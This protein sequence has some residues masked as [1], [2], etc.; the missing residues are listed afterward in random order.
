MSKKILV[1]EDEEDIR[2]YIMTLFED[3]GYRSL[4]AGNGREGLELAKKEA[5]DLITLDISMP[6]QSGVKTLRELQNH[7][8]TSSVPVVIVTGVSDDLQAYIQQRKQ[9]KPPAGYVFKPVERQELLETVQR[10]L[11]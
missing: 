10:L 1:I 5:P 2:N 8:A 3:H 7:P 4:G 6:E 9:L 11:S